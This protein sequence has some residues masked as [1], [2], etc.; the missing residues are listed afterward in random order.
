MKQHFFALNLVLKI[1]IL[2][3]GYSEFIFSSLFLQQKMYLT[4]EA[5]PCGDS[6]KYLG[7]LLLQEIQYPMTVSSS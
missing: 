4:L 2:G 5:I 7:L 6:R 3:K 1:K